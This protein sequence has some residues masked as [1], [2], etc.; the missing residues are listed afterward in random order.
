MASFSED[1]DGLGTGE[2]MNVDFGVN[3]G[4]YAFAPGHVAEADARQVAYQQYMQRRYAEQL[5]EMRARVIAEA[6]RRAEEAAR[7]EQAR[8]Q[9]VS[10]VMKTY[11]AVKTIQDAS[12]SELKNA[13]ELERVLELERLFEQVQAAHVVAEQNWWQSFAQLLLGNA[14]TPTHKHFKSALVLGLWNT[15][16]YAEQATTKGTIDPFTGDPYDRVFAF[17]TKSINFGPNDLTRVALDHFMST[18]G[19]LSPGSTVGLGDLM[20]ASVDE[21]V[22]H[23]NGFRVVEVLIASGNLTVGKLRILGGDGVLGEVERLQQIVPAHGV[24]EVSAYVIDGDPVVYADVCWDVRHAMSDIGHPLQTFD[25]QKQNPVYQFM[26][27]VD[28]PAFDATAKVQV[29]VL[30]PPADIVAPTQRHA[31]AT[32]DDVISLWRGSG[33]MA[34]D[35]QMNPKCIIH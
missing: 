30:S 31:Y 4:A 10:N 15:A 35:G 17:G 13:M 7:A 6:Q 29:H 34:Q 12:S 28:R 3:Y 8:L 24:S 20:G 18:F 9:A 2:A 21:L 26:G 1:F 11:Q 33:C 27:L 32:Y 16:E 22:C 23:S 19:L 14:A 25:P 5:Q